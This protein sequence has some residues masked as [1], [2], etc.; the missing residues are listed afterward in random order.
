MIGELKTFVVFL[1]VGAASAAV[2]CLGVLLTN[3]IKKR[4]LSTIL[5]SFLLIDFLA[6]V[7]VVF[8]CLVLKTN[9]GV[10]RMYM[11]IAVIVSFIVCQ[12]TLARL[13]AKIAAKVYNINNGRK[14]NKNNNN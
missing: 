5:E 7:F 13:F 9:F 10:M 6:A 12:K 8:F 2:F 4:K 14:K 11:P 3:S 1:C